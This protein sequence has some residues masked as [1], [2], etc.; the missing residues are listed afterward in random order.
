MI[1]FFTFLVIEYHINGKPYYATV[2]YER[3]EHCQE[4]MDQ[5]LAMPMYKHLFGLYGNT[6]M[7]KCYVSDDVSVALRP[8][9]RPDGVLLHLPKIRPD[10]V[11][12]HLPKTRPDDAPLHL[13]P[14]A[15]PEE[16]S[17]G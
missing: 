16:V 14:R 1:E 11:P 5:D 3:E 8:K 13:R 7:A 17:N 6:I 10:D 9:T 15:R 2:M 4:A 12:L